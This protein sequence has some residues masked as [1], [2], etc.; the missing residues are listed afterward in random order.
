MGISVAV[1]GP[2]GRRCVTLVRNTPLT[3]IVFFCAFGFYITL[4][5]RIRAQD[6]PIDIQNFRW[7]CSGSW[8]TAGLRRGEAL[9]VVSTPF[10]GS[11]RPHGPLV[12]FSADLVNVVL[13]GLSAE[14]S[15]RW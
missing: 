12:W 13:P 3:L 6:S 2:L 7:E 14:P 5:Y 1:F 9:W 15:R 4:Q 8:S 10:E 11:G